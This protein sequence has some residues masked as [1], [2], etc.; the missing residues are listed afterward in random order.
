MITVTITFQEIEGR[1]EPVSSIARQCVTKAEALALLDY[2]VHDAGE[3][4]SRIGE[5]ELNQFA[6]AP[7]LRAV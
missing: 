7:I 4:M 1:V 6:P 3:E 2:D 5:V